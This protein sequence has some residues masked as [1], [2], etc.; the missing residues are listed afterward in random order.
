MVRAVL[1]S[2]SQ[3]LNMNSRFIFSRVLITAFIMRLV[4]SAPLHSS[5]DND[6]EFANKGDFFHPAI[7][8]QFRQ[9]VRKLCFSGRR[10][11]FLG[12]DICS[13]IPVP[14]SPS[15]SKL[16]TNSSVKAFSIYTDTLLVDTNDPLAFPGISLV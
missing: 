14:F 3:S 7:R 1:F 10:T 11:F 12:L 9:R 8:Y 5:P 2:S 15:H 4:Y 16:Y 6:S 13:S